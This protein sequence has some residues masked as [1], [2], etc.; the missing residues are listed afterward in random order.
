MAI[1]DVSPTM[2]NAAVSCPRY[3][4]PTKKGSR[5]RSLGTDGTVSREPV[6][7]A[8]H[9]VNDTPRAFSDGDRKISL[10]V[11]SSRREHCSKSP[12]STT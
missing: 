5:P 7:M 1:L 3:L 11:V 2:R 6:R 12:Q 9:S 10:A 4:L 8:L